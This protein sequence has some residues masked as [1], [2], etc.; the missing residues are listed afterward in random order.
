MRWLAAGIAIVLLIVVGVAAWL[1]LPPP[2][3]GAG[4]RLGPTTW[5]QRDTEPGQVA[6]VI[7]YAAGAEEVGI[8]VTVFGSSSCP[9]KLRD[10]RIGSAEI[11]VDVRGDV[12][13]GACTADAAPH[14][15]GILVERQALPP[16]PFT[17]VVS[18][19]GT[20]DEHEV[21]ELP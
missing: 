20:V 17:V 10:V 18:H 11:E 7:V 9:P 4:W 1:F 15:F 6:E 8:G 16:L 21:T 12:H 19:A 13:F 2:T 5:H 3:S 14:S